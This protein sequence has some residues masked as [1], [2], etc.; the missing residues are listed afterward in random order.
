MPAVELEFALNRSTGRL[1]ESYIAMKQY[2]LPT[3]I[4]GSTVNFRVRLVKSNPAGGLGALSLIP[5][6]GLSM[7]VGIAALGDAPLTS[8]TLIVDGD[9][10]AGSVPLNVAAIT[11]LFAGS[12][13]SI[14]K[15]IEFRINDG[16]QY[17]PIQIEITINNSILTAATCRSDA[18]RRGVEQNGSGPGLCA[19]RWRRQ[20]AGLPD[21]ERRA[22]S[23]VF[24][25][26]NDDGNCKGA[27]G[28]ISMK[29]IQPRSGSSWWR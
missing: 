27:G 2:A 9:A 10:L 23:S 11:G 3:L 21:D 22:R 16:G 1:S 14:R 17:Q 8:G 7:S 25:P 19:A 29:G 28:V 20:W 5:L 13:Q 24:V 6:D 26:G 12:T 15:I 4:A 18:A